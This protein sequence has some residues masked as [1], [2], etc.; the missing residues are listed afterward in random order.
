MIDV[1]VEG[2]ATLALVDT[3]AAVSVMN[4]KLCRKIRKVTTPVSGFRLRTAN[5]EQ[6]EPLAACTARVV[7]QDALYII[8][9][10]VLTSCSHDI[11]LGWDFLSRH[12]AI[13]DCA[14]A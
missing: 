4:A 10:L 3:G 6:V 5:A 9:F 2:V 13:I 14:R 11:I 8:E 7:V 1:F 12:Q